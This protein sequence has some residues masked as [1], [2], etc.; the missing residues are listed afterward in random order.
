[1][2]LTDA[3]AAVAAYGTEEY[4]RGVADQQQ[5]V[6]IITAQLHTLQDA[7]DAYKVSHP[8]TPPPPPPTSK[9]VALKDF[10]VDNSAQSGVALW[11]KS[12]KFGSGTDPNAVIYR[13]PANS[14]SKT[15]VGSGTTP[16]FQMMFGGGG[17]SALATDLDVGGFTLDCPVQP[18][19][20]WFH[21][22]RFGYSKNGKLHDV[23]VRGA[24]GIGSSPPQETFAH[25]SWHS[26]N[27]ILTNVTL[28]GRNAAGTPVGATGWGGTSCNSATATNLKS[29]YMVHGFGIALFLCKGTYLIQDS[30]LRHNRKA[31]NIERHQGGTI[32]FLR[33]DFRDTGTAYIAQISSDALTIST[34]VTFEDCIFDGDLCTV[35]TY[36]T[37]A[38]K[39][40]NG[41]K[42]ADITRV[43][44]G[45][46]VPVGAKFQFVH[47]Q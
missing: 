16:W 26:D 36:G 30:D 8:D 5:K 14:S 24:H 34:K 2:T 29:N 40:T 17:S 33:C 37:A 43:D 4:N 1:M 27:E 11:T 46:V 31:I 23:I 32:K 45:K 3:T 20:L 13:M 39:G 42:D 9:V 19:D 18:N 44:A 41:Q 22:L 10:G 35:N 12:G 47:N 21:G 38:N 15:N 6:D 25:P 7:F 28:D